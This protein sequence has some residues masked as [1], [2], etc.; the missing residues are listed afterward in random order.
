[1][2]LLLLELLLELLRRE[3]FE[4]A[5]LTALEG[6]ERLLVLADDV[7][8][9]DGFYVYVRRILA[10][11]PYASAG[12]RA[13]QAREGLLLGLALGAPM[14][15]AEEARDMDGT[16]ATRGRL[17]LPSS[18]ATVYAAAGW[19][20]LRAYAATKL[21]PLMMNPDEKDGRSACEAKRSAAPAS[22]EELQRQFMREKGF[23]IDYPGVHL[24]RRR[25]DT[26]V[27]LATGA[28]VAALWARAEM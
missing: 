8:L 27:K 21:T 16:R 23:S 22:F 26:S 14:G 6:G 17:G 4:G 25:G 1:M 2:L 7:E 3:V 9:S 18:C 19:R 10:A 15:S 20:E 13:L 24:C 28:Q 12:E 11:N 5:P